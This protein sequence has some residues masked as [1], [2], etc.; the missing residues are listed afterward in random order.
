[1]SDT[2]TSE[3]ESEV[4]SYESVFESENE[5]SEEDGNEVEGDEAGGADPKW[6]GRVQLWDA[7]AAAAAAAKPRRGSLNL[8]ELDR[9]TRSLLARS[10]VTRRSEAHT[11]IL[12]DICSM[13]L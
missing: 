1:M 10:S 7:A 4:E 2:E 5:S 8:G 3:S 6:C 13:P 11:H 12:M 9:L